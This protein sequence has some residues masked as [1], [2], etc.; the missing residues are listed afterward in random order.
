VDGAAN[1]GDVEER[2]GLL[3]GAG[4]PEAGKRLLRIGDVGGAVHFAAHAHVAK[5]NHKRIMTVSTGLCHATPT[6]FRGI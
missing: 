5:R 2:I 4:A 1:L 6:E 3:R